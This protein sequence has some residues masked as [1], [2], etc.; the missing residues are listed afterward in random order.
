MVLPIFDVSLHA[1]LHIVYKKKCF[2]DHTRIAFSSTN[3]S[4]NKKIYQVL[5]NVSVIVTIMT[6]STREEP[7]NTIKFKLKNAFSIQ[8]YNYD[9]H[10]TNNTLPFKGRYCCNNS[11]CQVWYWD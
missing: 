1:R 8:F 5:L 4:L 10:I 6:G 7:F 3:I 2:Q 9:I 11:A